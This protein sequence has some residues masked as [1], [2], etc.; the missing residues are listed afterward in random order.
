M[1]RIFQ[2]LYNLLLEEKPE[3]SDV[4]IWLQGDRYDRG[5]KVLE[6]YK[7]K[8]AKLIII[9]GNDILIGPNVR[10]GEDNISLLDMKNYLLGS[11]VKGTDIL[12]DDGAFNTKDQALHII[13]SAKQKGWKKIILVSSAY[14][15]PRAFLSFVKAAKLCDYKGKIMNQSVYANN[16][17][18]ASGRA[19]RD[20]DL[21][22]EESKKIKD[23]QLRGDIAS[24]EEGFDY[25]KKTGDVR[26]KI[27]FRWA[28]INDADILLKWRNDP[29]TRKLSHNVA[30]IRM[31][32]HIKWLTSSLKDYSRKI[33]IVMYDGIPVGTIRTDKLG[34]VTEL[35]WAVA[36][37]ARGH[38]IGK[39]MIVAFVSQITGSIRAEIKVDNEAS[40][41]IAEYAGMKLDHKKSGVFH[42]QRLAVQRFKVNKRY[43]RNH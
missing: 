37:E 33:F 9:S 19:I 18:L 39:E 42:Y 3:K 8:L 10:P 31:K 38:G 15:Q 36:P 1:N 35:S 20:S 7:L 25:L 43:D 23:Y 30:V 14:H 17:E 5:N 2:K 21:M 4:V 16:D 13:K 11:G 22:K 12:I 24:Y 41:R 32:Q 29:Q 40:K 26:E 28:T 27:K 6:L 34:S